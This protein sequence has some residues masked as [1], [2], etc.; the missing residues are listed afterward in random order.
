M[1][2]ASS[3]TLHSLLEE[4]PVTHFVVL[5]NFQEDEAMVREHPKILAALLRQRDA[6]T[7]VLA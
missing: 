4:E 5:T 6:C 3:I 2:S 1:R 7:L